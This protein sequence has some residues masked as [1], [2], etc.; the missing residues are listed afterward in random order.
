MT[1]WIVL[2]PPRTSPLR[3]RYF[4]LLVLQAINYRCRLGTM[5]PI[6]TSKAYLMAAYELIHPATLSNTCLA[7]FAA[8][9]G[10][11]LIKA[12]WYGPKTTRSH[13]NNCML[14]S[15]T[16]LIGSNH[17]NSLPKIPHCRQKSFCR[18]LFQSRCVHSSFQNGEASSAR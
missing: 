1:Y 3:A 14:Q 15:T 17:F 18:A 10:T 9:A 2:T 6:F 7:R 4:R 16:K 11:S 13:T 12:I 5:L 8:I